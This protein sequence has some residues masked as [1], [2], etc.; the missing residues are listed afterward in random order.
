MARP[1]SVLELTKAEELELEQRMR[2]PTTS[3]RDCLRARIVLPRSRGIAQREVA[4]Q[5]GVSLPCVNKWSQRVDLAAP[6]G[7]PA[8]SKSRAGAWCAPFRTRR[9]RASSNRQARLDAPGRVQAAQG[10]LATRQLQGAAAVEEPELPTHAGARSPCGSRPRPPP[11]G[12]APSPPPP[13]WRGLQRCNVDP[14]CPSN[15]TDPHLLTA[16]YGACVGYG[17]CITAYR[18]EHTRA[19]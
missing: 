6:S 5:L 13:Q 19:P 1:V 8:C 16:P 17:R 3:Q 11:A 14:R 10:L 7:F 18:S 15:A 12:P 2:A 4:R 9:R